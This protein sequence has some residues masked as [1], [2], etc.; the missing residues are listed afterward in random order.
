MTGQTRCA[1]KGPPKKWLVGI[2]QRQIRYVESSRVFNLTGGRGGIR[3]HG[4][5]AG[6]PVF[7]TGALNHSATLPDQQDQA[8]SL[9]DDRTQRELGPSPDPKSSGSKKT[10]SE[11]RQGR[12]QRLVRLL[13]ALALRVVSQ[14]HRRVRRR[15]VS[16]FVER[17][18][19]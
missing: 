19:V 15:A 3:T 16:S 10:G 8:L 14:E 1:V 9:A 7:K 13:R 4:T 5:L 17:A 6:T 12:V 11:G 18:P 2:G